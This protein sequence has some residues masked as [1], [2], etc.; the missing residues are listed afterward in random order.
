MVDKL[1]NRMIVNVLGVPGI[2][3]LIGLG[4]Y[5]FALFILIVMIIALY[6][7]YLINRIKQ[8]NPNIWYGLTITILIALYYFFIPLL[9][10]YQSLSI[11]ISL[12][13]IAMITELFRRKPNSTHNL[14]STLA[15]ILY[16]PVLLGTLIALRNWDTA[17]GAHITYAVFISV[18]ICDSVAYAAGKLWGKKKIYPEVSPNKTVVGTVGGIFGALFTIV[19]LNQIGF[20]GIL[21]SWTHILI[22]T[23]IIGVFGQTGDFVESLFKRDAGIKD[24]GKLLMG[25]GGVLDRFDSLLLASPL[26]FIFVNQIFQY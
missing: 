7:F 17:N 4:S 20:L 9:N 6:E 5:Y 26:T 22:F 2:L 25:H 23:L 10:M 16:V 24:S 11:I 13:I 18:W 12:I 14:T 1:A 19:V 3:L 8:A 21:F 15:G